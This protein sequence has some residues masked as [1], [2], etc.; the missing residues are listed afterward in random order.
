MLINQRILVLMRSLHD[1]EHL[2]FG[3]TMIDEIGADVALL[4]ALTDKWEAYKAVV[5]REQLLF[6]VSKASVET[7]DIRGFDKRRDLIFREMRHRLKFYSRSPDA[8][9]AKAAA[10]LLFV[11]HP[12]DDT[13]NRNLF[14]ETAYVGKMLAKL[15]EAEHAEAVNRIYGFRQMMTELG[16]TNEALAE[17]YNQRLHAVEEADSLGRRLDVRREADRRIVDIFDAMNAFDTVNELTAKDAGLREPLH[18]IAAFVH[19]MVQQI[20]RNLSHRRKH[21]RKKDDTSSGDNKAEKASGGTPSGD[22]K[23][24][25]ES[26]GTP[27]GDNKGGKGSGSTPPGDNKTEKGSGGGRPAETLPSAQKNSD[28]TASATPSAPSV[29]AEVNVRTTNN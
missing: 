28:S 29:S 2:G 12:F 26:G 24:K 10:E 3:T 4:P 8:L 19:A 21:K 17:R 11:M 27:S 20:E 22:N 5:N 14:G 13:A 9:V 7:G 18:R 15:D 23:G 25:K 16:A 1:D 6:S